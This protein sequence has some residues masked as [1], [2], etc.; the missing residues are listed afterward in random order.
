[1][2]VLELALKSDELQLASQNDAY[3]LVGGWVAGWTEDEQQDKFERLVKCLRLHHMSAAF[4]TSVVIWSNFRHEW[5]GLLA[6]CTNA[7]TYQSVAASLS[8]P[9]MGVLSNSCKPR[10][11]PAAFEYEFEAQLEL[12]KFRKKKGRAIWWRLGVADGYLIMLVVAKKPKTDGQ[13][14]VGLYLGLK[15][16]N[17]TAEEHNGGDT[18]QSAGPIVSWRVQVNGRRR[19]EHRYVHG[20]NV[21]SKGFPDFFRKPYDEVVREGSDYFPQ[22]RMTVKVKA[23]FIFDRH[24][25]SEE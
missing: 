12:A 21:H 22:G 2:E 13:A 20:M 11:S 16:P 6:L 8:S 23:R 1:M 25:N 14:A 15:R 19:G 10:R 9:K 5:P 4:L 3:A 24:V 18:V 7:L 17:V